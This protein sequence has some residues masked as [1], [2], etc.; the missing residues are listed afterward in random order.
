MITLKNVEKC[1]KLKGGLYYVLQQIS[2]TVEQGEFISIMGP[3]GAGKST[4]LNILGLHDANWEGEYHFLGQQVHKLPPKERLALQKK[5]T[6]FV[7]QS[8]HLLDDLTVYEN[9]ELPLAYRDVPKKDREAIVCDVQEG[10]PCPSPK[11]PTDRSTNHRLSPMRA[12]PVVVFYYRKFDG[13]WLLSAPDF[14][15]R[16]L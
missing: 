3:S 6:G 5:H 15:H 2:F 16:F 9:I 10:C 7:F 13:N 14:A 12:A 8:Y 4:L 11:S 1:Y